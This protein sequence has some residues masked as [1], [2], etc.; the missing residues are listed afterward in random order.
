MLLTWRVRL[1]ARSGGLLLTWRVC[2]RVR[3]GGAAA[4][5]ADP[6]EC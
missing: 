5:V 3:S 2:L 1:R 4:D 6:S